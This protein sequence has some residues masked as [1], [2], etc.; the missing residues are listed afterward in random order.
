MITVVGMGRKSTDLTTEG[1]KAVREA[2][3]VVVKSALTHAWNC[4]LYTS[5]SPRDTR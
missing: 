5:P 3:V 2:D 1:A 4:L